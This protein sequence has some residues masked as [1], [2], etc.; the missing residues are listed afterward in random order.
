MK[1]YFLT[2]EI[3]PFSNTSFLSMFSKFVPI[4]LQKNNH[5]IRL[6][7]PKYGFISER[8]YTL[9]EVIRLR[10]INTKIGEGFEVASANQLLFLK[11]EFKSILWNMK[12]FFNPLLLYFIKLKMEDHF[13]IM[14]IDLDF[15]QKCH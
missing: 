9:R 12:I 10:E 8:K 13:Q 15:F 4:N 14:V 1:I 3:F 11:L 5:D 7:S 2:P 6:T